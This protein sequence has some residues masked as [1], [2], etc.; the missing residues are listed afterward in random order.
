MTFCMFIHCGFRE[1][2]SSHESLRIQTDRG[3]IISNVAEKK[4]FERPSTGSKCSGKEMTH[5]TNTHISLARTSH[6]GPNLTTRN[7]EG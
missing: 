1:G 3:A 6:I 2:D 5:L 7:G 4:S